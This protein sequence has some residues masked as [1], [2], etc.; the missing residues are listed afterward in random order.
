[1]DAFRGRVCGGGDRRIRPVW[2]LLL[3]CWPVLIRFGLSCDFVICES[4]DAWQAV[5]S[6]R[7][8]KRRH[9]WAVG[10]TILHPVIDP[11]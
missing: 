3:C 5:G 8:Q 2:I 9:E 4:F 1:M 6:T 11:Y 10:F 7:V